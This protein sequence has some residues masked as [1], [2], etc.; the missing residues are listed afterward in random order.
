MAIVLGTSMQHSSNKCSVIH[1]TTCCQSQLVQWH[2]LCSSDHESALVKGAIKL[3][4]G[5]C[6]LYLDTPAAIC[7]IQHVRIKIWPRAGLTVNSPWVA[8]NY[9][10]PWPWP[11]IGS[12][13]IQSCTTHRPLSTYQISLKSE[14]LCGRTNRRD[15][16]KFKVTW[17]K[18]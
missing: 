10:W 5:L 8:F 18:N 2:Y 7:L 15:R 13:G 4:S 17:H 11:W 6:T 16:T 12:Y 3:I 9:L 14:K 1:I